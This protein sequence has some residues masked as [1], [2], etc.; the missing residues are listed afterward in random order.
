M[1]EERLEKRKF[2]GGNVEENQRSRRRKG[3]V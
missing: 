2:E 1:D 3:Q